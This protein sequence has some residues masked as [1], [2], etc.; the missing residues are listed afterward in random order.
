MSPRSEGGGRYPLE[1]VVGRVP[2]E[3]GDG[4]VP[5]Q[6]TDI[7]QV[8]LG[9]MLMDGQQASIGID[10]LDPD[11]FYLSK[12]QHIFNAMRGLYLNGVAI[13]METISNRLKKDS[14]LDDVG[15]MYY[16]TELVTRVGTIENTEYH[17]R[18]LLEK[19]LK[20]DQIELGSMLVSQGYSED[21]DAFDTMDEAE[22]TLHKIDPKERRAVAKID[23]LV[24]TVFDRFKRAEERD[25]MTG[26]PSGFAKLDA[27]TH[28][29]EGGEDVVIGAD[30]SQGKTAFALSIAHNLSVRGDI[31]GLYLTAEMR[32]SELAERLLFVESSVDAESAKGGRLV[33]RDWER[34]NAARKVVENAKLIVQ[35]FVGCTMDDMRSS[36]RRHVRFGGAKYVV[37]DYLQKIEGKGMG[38]EQQVSSVSDMIKRCALDYDVPILNLSQV[39]LPPGS[40]NKRPDRSHLRGSKSIAN[41]ADIVLLLYRAEEYGIEY[42]EDLKRYTRG[43]AEIITGKQRNGLRGPSI[44]LTWVSQ[45]ATFKDGTPLN[46]QHT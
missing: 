16:L 11:T 36:I 4:R 40:Q 29:F 27:L 13:D 26:L 10:M 14:V 19:A 44:L 1:K 23:R 15:G 28:G 6:A 9:A 30:T 20:R 45:F 43:L 3:R 33:S 35:P 8:V 41:D 24:D 22:T 2:R 34:L 38:L 25:G 42:D 37:V 12:H 5:P 39:T 46:M 21:F 7:E 32:P 18:I 17:C 31:P